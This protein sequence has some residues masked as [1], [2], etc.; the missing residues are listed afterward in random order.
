MNLSHLLVPLHLLLPLPLLLLLLTVM[1]KVKC[2]RCIILC[3][4]NKRQSKLYLQFRSITINL[5]ME[6]YNDY[7]NFHYELMNVALHYLTLCGRILKWKNPEKYL[8]I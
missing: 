7:N 8:Q 3:I 6:A 5:S 2:D 1:V 4:C